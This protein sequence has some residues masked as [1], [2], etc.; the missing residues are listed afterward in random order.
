MFLL[1]GPNKHVLHYKQNRL[2]STSKYK[3]MMLSLSRKKK[4]LA[5]ATK[6]KAIQHR[7][8]KG[9]PNT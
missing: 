5:E 8:L 2:E 6:T 1:A 9:K 3:K 7:Y 4:K